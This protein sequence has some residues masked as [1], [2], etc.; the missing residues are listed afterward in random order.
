MVNIWMELQLLQ[1]KSDK[2][3]Q[4]M[5]QGTLNM[6]EISYYNLKMTKYDNKLYKA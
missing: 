5:I 2:I 4:Y 1:F 3:W 6:D